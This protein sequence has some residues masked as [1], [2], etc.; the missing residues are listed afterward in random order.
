M[1]I[2]SDQLFL[3]NFFAGIAPSLIP[4]AKLISLLIV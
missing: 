4:L 3:N 1:L 2:S